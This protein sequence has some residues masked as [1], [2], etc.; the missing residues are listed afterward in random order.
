MRIDEDYLEYMKRYR[1][2]YHQNNKERICKKSHDYYR[3][4]R[5]KVLSKEKE[6]RQ[7]PEVKQKLKLKR[8]KYMIKTDVI[9][10]KIDYDKK[11]VRGKIN[12]KKI[13]EIEQSLSFIKELYYE[14][15][16]DVTSIA[17]KLDTSNAV[18]LAVLRRNNLFV[19]PK[20]FHNQKCLECSNGLMVKSNSERRI[21]ELLLQSQVSFVYEQP[22]KYG[23]TTY[24][25]DFYFP[26]NDLYVEYAGLMD[27]RWYVAQL[28][29]KKYAMVDLN[30]NYVIITKP[31][32]IVEVLA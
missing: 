20:A 15:N 12:T 3:D 2:L 11:Y 27:K 8:E 14:Q 10:R 24:Y 26:E 6:R 5:E 29:K 4:N 32:Q 16:L 7:I 18:I 30:K 31:E 22:V 9:L 1:L 17:K 23:D 25:P 21:V 28:E 13:L 19:K